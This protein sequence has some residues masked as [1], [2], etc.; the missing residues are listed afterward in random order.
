MLFFKIKLHVLN[1]KLSAQIALAY[2]FASAAWPFLHSV[3]YIDFLGGYIQ[4]RYA[5]CPFFKHQVVPEKNLNEENG[6]RL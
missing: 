1:L 3:F 2:R 5:F 6:A 4:Y